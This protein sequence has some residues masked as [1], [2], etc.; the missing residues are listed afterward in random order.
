MKYSN[1]FHITLAKL[2][3]TATRSTG[4]DITKLTDHLTLLPPEPFIPDS[5]DFVESIITS[6][7][8]VYKRIAKIKL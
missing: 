2:K 3:D 1:R 5:V 8:P 7:G 4:K 6:K